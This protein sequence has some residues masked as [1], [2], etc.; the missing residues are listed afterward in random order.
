MKW[1]GGFCGVHFSTVKTWSG[2]GDLDSTSNNN[3]GNHFRGPKGF[4][5]GFLG[6]L[7]IFGGGL[8]GLGPVGFPKTPSLDGLGPV[9]GGFLGKTLD[10]EDV[11]RGFSEIDRGSGFLGLLGQNSRASIDF[12]N[13]S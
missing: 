9:E 11:F 4:L 2:G 3:P 5:G 1:R 8:W 13:F 12:K 6:F 10:R 7:K